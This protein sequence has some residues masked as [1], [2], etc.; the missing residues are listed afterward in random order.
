MCGR[1]GQCYAGTVL[2]SPIYHSAITTEQIMS[3]TLFSLH[4]FFHPKTVKTGDAGQSFPNFDPGNHTPPDY[5]CS[6]SDRPVK[7]WATL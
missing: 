6:S 2:D 3:T 1:H 5:T 4:L 7:T